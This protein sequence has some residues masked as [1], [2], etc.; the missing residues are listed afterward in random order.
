[1][2]LDKGLSQRSCGGLMKPLWPLGGFV[3]P[4]VASAGLCIAPLEASQ[5]LYLP[6]KQKHCCFRCNIV[7]PQKSKYLCYYL[8]ITPDIEHNIYSYIS[9]F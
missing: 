2:V 7:Y 5:I 9:S 6:Y 8:C 1:M 4:L 3:K